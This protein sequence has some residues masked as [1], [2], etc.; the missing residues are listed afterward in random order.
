MAKAYANHV[1]L[2]SLN[3]VYEFSQTL[4]IAI[5]Q[6]SWLINVARL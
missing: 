2:S 4:F 6:A 3:V 1:F 5:H